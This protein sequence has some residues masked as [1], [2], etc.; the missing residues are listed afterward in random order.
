M[1]SEDKEK[2]LQI[3]VELDAKLEERFERIQEVLGIA[4]RADEIRHLIAIF[5]LPPPRFEHINTYEDRITIKDNVLNKNVNVYLREGGL[6]HCDVC[7]LNDCQHID[8]ALSI[9]QVI[10][11]LNARGW[12]RKR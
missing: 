10:R 6:V 11:I 3:R 2:G 9:P 7:G 4:S 5:P 8:Y 12:K 1:S